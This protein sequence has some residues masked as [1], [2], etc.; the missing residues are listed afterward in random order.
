MISLGVEINMRVNMNDK[1]S[2]IKLELGRRRALYEK[3]VK[4][5][6]S[7]SEKER[8]FYR[9]KASGLEDMMYLLIKNLE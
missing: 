8:D 3:I 9:G 5:D 2:E 4:Y 7:I 6:E 1:I